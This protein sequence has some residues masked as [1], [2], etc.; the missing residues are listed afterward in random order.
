MKILYKLIKFFLAKQFSEEVGYEAWKDPIKAVAMIDDIH[1]Y[2]VL[3]WNSIHIITP[4]HSYE[5]L[6]RDSPYRN[7]QPHFIQW[8]TAS[9]ANHTTQT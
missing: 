8:Y 5:T 7:R 1:R 3:M 6:L 2:K 4:T 9:A